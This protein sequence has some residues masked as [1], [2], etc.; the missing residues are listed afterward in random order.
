V[1]LLSHSGVFTTGEVN[2]RVRRVVTTAVGAALAATLVTAGP[3]SS[4]PAFAA[5]A[6]LP[7]VTIT[8]PA[9]GTHVPL[10]ED[11]TI[12]ADAV[13]ASEDKPIVS[14]TFSRD[15]QPVATDTLGG[16]VTT[17]S[18]IVAPRV[19]AKLPR[20]HQFEH[21]AL[22]RIHAQTS[23]A[24]AGAVWYLQRFHYKTERWVT[25]AKRHIHANRH[26][27]FA[28]RM[29]RV[30]KLWWLRILRPATARYGETSKDFK[31]FSD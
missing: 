29:P 13:P 2:W 6:T 5:D 10:F 11:F 9:S 15:G 17:V 16:A 3:G 27:T 18:A 24:E 23:P 30:G 21:R 28:V 1:S 8:L 7:T 19:K 22:A 4:G 25:V 31:L 12:E 14:V 20:H 26:S